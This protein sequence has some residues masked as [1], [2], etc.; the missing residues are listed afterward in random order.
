[1]AVMMWCMESCQSACSTRY[2][3]LATDSTTHMGKLCAKRPASHAIL[4]SWLSSFM[5][6]RHQNVTPLEAPATA[7]PPSGVPWHRGLSIHVSQKLRDYLHLQVG[8]QRP[9]FAA[10]P[11]PLCH[12][13][14][15]LRLEAHTRFQVVVAP[16]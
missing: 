12:R 11:V 3:M 5:I 14:L 10:M 8:R 16:A 4:M 13:L 6:F 7:S 1:M 9:S 15:P 2:T